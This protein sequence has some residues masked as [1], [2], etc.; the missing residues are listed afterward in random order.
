MNR[1]TSVLFLN[2][3]AGIWAHTATDA[4]LLNRLSRQGVKVS[5]ISCDGYV[6]GLCPVR[7]SRGRTL[8]Q[9][10]ARPNLDCR[11][12][13]FTS[14]LTSSFGGSNPVDRFQLGEFI[15]LEHRKEV[16]S[17]FSSWS[18]S[19]FPID[20]DFRGIPVPRLAGYEVS[21]KYKSW[22]VA[23]SGA[24]SAEYH[25]TVRDVCL[26][27]A[28]ATEFFAQNLNFPTVVI[29][30]PHY[31]TNGA[32]ARVAREKGLRVIFL[33]GS[34]NISEDYTHLMLW[35][36]GQYSSANPAI[37]YFDQKNLTLDQS[38]IKRLNRHF[39]AL[40]RG[41][42]HKAYSAAK[43][44]VDSA[45]S[46]VG[47]DRGKPTA[48]LALSSMDESVAA[49]KVGVNSSF[50]YP[51]SVFS[52]QFEWVRETIEWFRGNQ[53]L[54]LVVRVHPREFP[55][56]RESK[57]SPAGIR[58]E[59]DLSQLPP[60]VFLNH[61]NQ[62][63]S[64]YDFLDEVDVLVTGWSSVGLEAAL[65]DVALITYDS[66][67][68]GYPASIGLTG[69]SKEEYFQN[70]E[71]ALNGTTVT[72]FREN[73]QKW[74]HLMMNVGTTRLGG[75][76]LASRRNLMPRWAN[77]I[78]EGL[79]RYLYFIY[80]PLDLWRGILFEPT[81]GKFEKVVLEGKSNLYE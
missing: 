2:S 7:L 71:T 22:D 70:L 72:P 63:L 32:F 18:S 51:G 65:Q 61:P 43:S 69:N 26:T 12:C 19:G 40:K 48:L 42:S 29:R 11:D 8:E 73:A 4:L 80:R 77:L 53:S 67:L 14:H 1:D 9:A 35:D 50:K 74:M 56:K 6:Q 34:A 62:E 78:L 58:W 64:V 30:S 17:F 46:Q 15:S 79:D 54:Q 28:A 37:H 3:A 47:A 39:E 27:V 45:I 55:N 76:F 10:A 52:D 38:S 41:T 21:L 44:G 24:G 60:N 49:Q 75:R 13:K 68:P 16:E 20:F 66:A 81:D 31:A 33:D 23:T 5:T 36:W 59:R 25:L 57:T